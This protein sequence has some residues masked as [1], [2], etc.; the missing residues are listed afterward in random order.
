LKNGGYADAA[1]AAFA[2]GGGDGVFAFFAGVFDFS[3]ADA[4]WNGGYADAAAAF[5]GGDAGFGGGGIGAVLVFDAIRRLDASTCNSLGGGA[6]SLGGGAGL[7]ALLACPMLLDLVLLG[8]GGSDA[9]LMGMPAFVFFIRLIA[10]SLV[11]DGIR[12]S[13]F[14]LVGSD[15]T[16]GSISSGSFDGVGG[17]FAAGG[18]GGFAFIV[19]VF[20]A[21]FADAAWDVGYADATAVAFA[22]AAGLLA[23]DAA[24]L[25]KKS[26]IA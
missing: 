8:G 10:A 19:G 26:P 15:G 23:R 17:A 18:D 1:A 5:V 12:S 4:A 20:A 6:S 3:F 11:S 13:T 16:D 21:T 22:F 7:L 2:G 24:K 14:A 25:R 9:D